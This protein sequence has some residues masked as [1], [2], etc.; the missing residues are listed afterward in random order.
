MVGIATA[1]VSHCDILLEWQKVATRDIGE[2]RKKQRQQNSS[3][4]TRINRA[5]RPT[6]ARG[7][8]LT[9]PTL[10]GTRAQKVRLSRE[11][12]S[13]AFRPRQ[14]SLS[15]HPASSLPSPPSS[16]PSPPSIT[17]KLQHGAREH[18]LTFWHLGIEVLHTS[19]LAAA[20]RTTLPPPILC[21]AVNIT[22]DYSGVCVPILAVAIEHPT[23][24]S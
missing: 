5:K 24:D 2:A 1:K 15:K 10:A 18:D 13:G 17:I 23:K 11:Q 9:F 7:P 22:S 19:Q 6:H 16:L 12:H 20:D 21:T 3:H 4:L 14:L 8:D